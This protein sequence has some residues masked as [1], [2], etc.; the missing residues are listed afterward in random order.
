MLPIWDMVAP[1]HAARLT[2]S[3][4]NNQPQHQ[5]QKPQHEQA[6]SVWPNHYDG[7][8]DEIKPWLYTSEP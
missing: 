6:L 7:D 2:E 5:Q 1:S 8:G 4:N 3:N